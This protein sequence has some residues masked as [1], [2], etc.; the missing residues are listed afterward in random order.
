MSK[1][2]ISTVTQT[3]KSFSPYP[4]INF[5]TVFRALRLKTDRSAT[6]KILFKV[7]FKITLI[8]LTLA[9]SSFLDTTAIF[10]GKVR[11]LSC[12]SLSLDRIQK[13]QPYP[14]KPVKINRSSRNEIIDDHSLKLH[15]MKLMKEIISKLLSQVYLKVIKTLIKTMN[16]KNLVSGGFDHRSQ[17]QEI[18]SLT[19]SRKSA[20]R[21]L[22]TL[23][24]LQSF[25]D[26]SHQT[27]FET[28]IKIKTQFETLMI[29]HPRCVSI[30]W[31]LW[32]GHP[33]CSNSC[34]LPPRSEH[35]VSSRSNDEWTNG[36]DGIMINVLFISL[37][38]GCSFLS[39]VIISWRLQVSLTAVLEVDLAAPS[40]FGQQ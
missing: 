36:M 2:R 31:S 33:Q 13:N 5:S 23:I 35:Q 27:Q 10:S 40:P 3:F 19:P 1:L 32:A 21:A 6:L 7:Y 8:F 29:Q 37:A 14:R 12:L 18:L 15:S 38:H 34:P 9:T 22:L 17:S 11:F 16:Y 20:L 28:R 30:S 4:Q 26:C 39:I 25:L 24:F